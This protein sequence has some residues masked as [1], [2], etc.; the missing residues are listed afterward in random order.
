MRFFIFCSLQ[1]KKKHHHS[2]NTSKSGN[3]TSEDNDEQEEETAMDGSDVEKSPGDDVE[4]LEEAMNNLSL[5]ENDVTGLN[6]EDN[7]CENKNSVPSSCKDAMDTSGLANESRKD[8]KDIQ[9]P[10]N[11]RTGEEKT[12][13]PKDIQELQNMTTGEEKTDEPKDIQELQNMTTGEEKTDEPKDIQELQN[14]TTEENESPEDEKVVEMNSA[15]TSEDFENKEEP[16][17]N[18]DA[19]SAASDNVKLSKSP[20]EFPDSAESGMNTENMLASGYSED[21]EQ[22]DTGCEETDKE[23]QKEPRDATENDE[24]KSEEKEGENTRLCSDDSKDSENE[25]ATTCHELNLGNVQNT[26]NVDSAKMQGNSGKDS[27][28]D[29]ANKSNPV[30]APSDLVSCGN[31]S[32]NNLKHA[33]KNTP[34]VSQPISELNPIASNTLNQEVNDDVS[35]DSA[36]SSLN[37]LKHSGVKINNDNQVQKN[38]INSTNSSDEFSGLHPSNCAP[39]NKFNFPTNDVSSDAI[40]SCRPLETSVKNVTENQ[41]AGPSNEVEGSKSSVKDAS[42]NKTP[43]PSN[44]VEGSESS[45]KDA[46]KNKT[47]GPSNEVEGSESSVKDASKNKTPGPSNEVEPVF[48]GSISDPDPVSI[49]DPSGESNTTTHVSNEL[50]RDPSLLQNPP[51]YD[52][53]TATQ[54]SEDDGCSNESRELQ[55]GHSH[56]GPEDCLNGGAETEKLP[57]GASEILSGR[58]SLGDIGPFNPSTMS[59]ENCLNKFCYPEKLDGNNKFKCQDCNKNT[60]PEEDD[61]ETAGDKNVEEN[62]KNDGRTSSE[63][64]G[65]VN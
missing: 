9:E 1:E 4:V 6:V 21:R 10:R 47:P 24:E 51:N 23:I 32:L 31:G 53:K 44:E 20:V 54:P 40:A 15:E 38:A 2:S 41:A 35:S 62:G 63:K 17:T 52:S 19:G 48:N 45:V 56:S 22:R 13:E 7:S 34:D 12:D 16:K 26:H 61:E 33:F 37:D 5:D 58:H 60:R 49:S 14:M 29:S 39:K 59:V 46:S 64:S 8:I 43:G 57:H 42:K 18:K 11:T 28:I 25:V 30:I 55:E 27:D 65:W 3:K 50:E 36:V